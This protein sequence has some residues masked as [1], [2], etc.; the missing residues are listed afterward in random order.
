LA[1][2]RAAKK[3]KLKFTELTE[4]AVLTKKSSS[5][6]NGD[7]RFFSETDLRKDDKGNI[8][9]RNCDY[10][11]WYF[12]KIV[13]DLKEEI[14]Q[15][16]F[17]IDS[18]KYPQG[19]LAEA[20][21]GLSNA[22]KRLTQMQD[23][24]P[25]YSANKDVLAKM[26]SELGEKIKETMSSRSEQKK[27]LADPHREVTI[28][29]TPCIDISSSPELRRLADVNGVSHTKGKVTGCD[30]GKMWQWCRRAI[31]EPSNLEWLRKD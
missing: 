5:Y 31:N 24:L 13:Q 28:D 20:K 7:V 30:A 8:T 12:P 14:R 16:K 21:E 29:T 4:S 27:G 1:R 3:E 6:G 9:G 22:E 11:R 19:R 17:A 23:S 25:D 15:K 18:G 26:S 2:A 10:P